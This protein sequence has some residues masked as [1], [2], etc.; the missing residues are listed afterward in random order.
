MLV[1]K[2]RLPALLAVLGACLLMAALVVV[3]QYQVV[4]ESSSSN[5]FIELEKEYAK[6]HPVYIR[7]A[8]KVDMPDFVNFILKTCGNIHEIEHLHHTCTNAMRV[9]SFRGIL[10]DLTSLQAKS[11]AFGCCW[12]TVMEAY[13][14]IDANVSHQWRLWQGTLSGKAGVTF[15]D[16]S[17]GNSVGEKGYNQLKKEVGDLTRVV[18]RQEDYIDQVQRRELELERM[19]SSQRY[20]YYDP[21]YYGRGGGGGGGDSE[22]GYDSTTGMYWKDGRP[23]SLARTEES[24]DASLPAPPTKMSKHKEEQAD[25]RLSMKREKAS[26]QQKSLWPSWRDW[27]LISAIRNHNAA[28]ASAYEAARRAD[29]AAREHADMASAYKQQSND[30]SSK[31]SDVVDSHKAA[32]DAAGIA[33]EAADYAETARTEAEQHRDI[34]KHARDVAV[35]AVSA[36]SGGAPLVPLSGTV[37]PTGGTA[38]FFAQNDPADKGVKVLRKQGVNV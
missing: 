3:H 4:L 20:H 34:A 31:Y 8:K 29:A 28:A 38:A 7:C 18:A 26:T 2:K 24:K 9:E 21:Y 16:E 30:I 11:K 5:N 37:P 23:A 27:L 14:A 1:T 15:E 12:E 35:T 13:E 6:L 19:I 25:R 36:T 33:K 22:A 17:C 10:V 32:L